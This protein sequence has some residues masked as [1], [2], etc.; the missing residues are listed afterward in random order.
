MIDLITF[1]IL[2]LFEVKVEDGKHRFYPGPI[3]SK[4]T[5]TIF[6]W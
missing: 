1:S 6:A 4:T 5:V 3:W 2:T